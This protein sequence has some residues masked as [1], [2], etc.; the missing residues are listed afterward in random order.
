MRRRFQLRR[1]RRCRARVSAGLVL[2]FV[3]VFISFTQAAPPRSDVVLR[4]TKDVFVRQAAPTI[5][6]GN[7]G[8]LAVAGESAVN[9]LGAP[10]GRCDTVMQFDISGAIL[11]F[12]AEF[13]VGAWTLTGARLDVTEVG[14]PLNTIFNRGVGEFQVSWL[15]SDAWEEGTGTPMFPAAGTGSQITW[16]LLEL[17]LTTATLAPM[18]QFTSTG[19]D[20][21]VS[22]DLSLPAEFMTDFNA[23]GPVSLYFARVTPTL[24]FTGFARNYF[25]DTSRPDLVL[26][27]ASTACGDVNCDGAVAIDD[28]EPFVLALVD[29]AEYAVQYPGCPISRADLSTDGLVDGGDVAAF[30]ACLVGGS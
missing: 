22:F 15:S 19:V 6:Y 20:G 29:P 4:P 18:G 2:L 30:V 3:L 16:N 24:G 8:A 11:M 28:I 1:A 7:A 10:Q 27:A 26:T 17:I 12:D 13:G 23:G 21:R 25:V 14:A 9:G 5:N